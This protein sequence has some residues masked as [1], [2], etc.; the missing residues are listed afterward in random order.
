MLDGR[1]WARLVQTSPSLNSESGHFSRRSSTRSLGSTMRC[2]PDRF[3]LVRCVAHMKNEMRLTETDI[4][5]KLVCHDLA[6]NVFSV[7]STDPY[8][9]S[10]EGQKRRW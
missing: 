9:V 8:R 5:T 3:Y 6:G 7:M 10:G 4:E 2:S 1:E